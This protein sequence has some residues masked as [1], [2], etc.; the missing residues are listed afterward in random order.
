[1]KKLAYDYYMRIS[2]SIPVGNCH[3]TIK[4][5]PKNTQR[6]RVLAQKIDISATSYNE[7]VD[8]FGNRQIYGGVECAH[9]I[10]VFHPFP[11]SH[12]FSFFCLLFHL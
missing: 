10:F 8:G 11:I 6:Q 12:Y 2:Y 5:F 3:F 1:M 9:D 4:C 7:G